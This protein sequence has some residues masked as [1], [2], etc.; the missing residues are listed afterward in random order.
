[1]KKNGFRMV[2]RISLACLILTAALQIVSVSAATPLTSISDTLERL[3]VN[4]SANQTINFTTGDGAANGETIAIDFPVGSWSNFGALT[5]ADIELKD[6]SNNHVFTDAADCT[7][8]EEVGVTVGANSITLEF[9]TGDGGFVSNGVLTRIYIGNV[10]GMS[11]A[12]T[13][14]LANPAAAGTYIVDFT[15]GASD[16]GSAAVY[17]VDDDQVQITAKVDPTLTFD[18]DTVAAAFPGSETAA[19]YS[20]DFGTLNPAAVNTSDNSTINSIFVDFESN[21]TSGAVI[22]VE[23]SNAGLTST[24]VGKTIASVSAALTAGTEGYGVCLGSINNMT[25]A[26]PY[27]SGACNGLSKHT[28]G[29]LQTSPQTILTTAGPNVNGRA[30]VYV[31]AA[32]SSITPAAND[33]SDTITFIA[34]GTF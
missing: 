19:P 3:K 26:L 7:G 30:E 32:I 22:T 12:G 33:Y 24:A 21:A 14:K 11:E 28:V 5:E 9:C 13:N 29:Q 10:A 17:I 20:V 8:T 31:K 6:V 23:D 4:E 2:V 25:G 16:T 34:T 18:L 1:M 15:V 27:L